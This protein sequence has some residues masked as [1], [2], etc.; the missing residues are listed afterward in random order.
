VTQ[1]PIIDLGG[2]GHVDADPLISQTIDQACRETGFLVISN[3]GVPDQV[4]H[5]CWQNCLDFFDLPL[6]ERMKVALPR[7]GYPYGY[8]PMANETLSKSLGEDS[9]P[10]LK[11]GF[12]VGPLSS[13]DR[14]LD[15]REAEFVYAPNLWPDNPVGLRAAYEVYVQEMD[16]L[17]QRLMGLFALALD[18]PGDFF[19]PYINEPISACRANHYPAMDSPPAPGQLRAGAHSDYGS[20]TILLPHHTPGG[21]QVQTPSGDWIDAPVI[22]GTFIINIGDLMARWTN[23]RWVSTLHRVVTPPLDA[24]ASARRLSIAFFHQPNWHAN[25][26]CLPSCL[27]EGEMPLYGPVKSGPYLMEKFT[28]TVM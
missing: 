18:L 2:R 4:I 25:I 6:S 12:A 1:I 14:A 23:D 27:A 13:P 28:S 19:V 11:E 10:D 24:G 20:L 15:P 9:P 21:L 3:H 17:A 5:D 16:A 26:T 22:P 7:P 8:G